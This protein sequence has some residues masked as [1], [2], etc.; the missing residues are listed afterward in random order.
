MLEIACKPELAGEVRPPFQD[1]SHS[2]FAGRSYG[3]SVPRRPCCG[4]TNR[5]DIRPACIY[6]ILSLAVWEAFFKSGIHAA[7]TGNPVC[8]AGIPDPGVVGGEGRAS[9]AI[10]MPRRAAAAA[11]ASGGT[12]PAVDPSNQSLEWKSP[13]CSMSCI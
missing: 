11:A 9:P 3:F 5:L 2:E 1:F 7:K 6:E 10:R 13:C 8:P 12:R 4:P